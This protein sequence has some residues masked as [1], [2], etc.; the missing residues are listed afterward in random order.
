MRS[1]RSLVAF[2]LLSLIGVMLCCNARD[3]IWLFLA[4][5]LTSLPTY[6]L[7]TISRKD[8]ASH[9]HVYIVAIDPTDT[10]IREVTLREQQTELVD[11]RLLDA[12][13]PKRVDEVPGV[14]NKFTYEL[15]K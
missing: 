7:V 8:L 12:L 2:F 9:Q 15:D 4:L 3:L 11:L 13:D 14:Q 6:V 10:A 5:E 1:P